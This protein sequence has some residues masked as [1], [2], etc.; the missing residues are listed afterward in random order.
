MEFSFWTLYISFIAHHFVMFLSFTNHSLAHSHASWFYPSSIKIRNTGEKP[1]LLV[2]MLY[3]QFKSKM[4]HSVNG[5]PVCEN[6]N[7][8]TGD[9][10]ASTVFPKFCSIFPSYSLSGNIGTPLD[11]PSLLSDFPILLGYSKHCFFL[12]NSWFYW[13]TLAGTLIAQ[14]CCYIIFLTAYALHLINYYKFIFFIN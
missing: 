4:W 5:I 8:L 3:L 2:Q 9:I 6:E 13:L 10:K 7:L 12:L 1:C 14:Y 11:S